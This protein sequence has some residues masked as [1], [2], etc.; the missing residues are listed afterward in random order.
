MNL[1]NDYSP[2]NPN[3]ERAVLG[4]C[5]LSQEALSSAV[6]VLKPD[7]FYVTDNRIA[8]EILVEMYLADKPVD[9]VTFSEELKGRGVYDRLGGQPFLAEL[10]GEITTT[11]NVDY[12]AE[13]VREYAIRRR[14]IYAG[15]KII[16]LSH[17]QDLTTKE[18]VEEI[19]KLILEASEN[20]NSS[21]FRHVREIIGPVFVDVEERY[22]NTGE[23]FSGFSSGFA[24]LDNL[25]GGFQPG[26]LNII[27]ARPS[28]GKTAFAVT[29]KICRY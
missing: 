24:D 17:R 7:D 9:L 4:A 8:Y 13:I 19:E 23:E 2:N 18:I 12:H 25:T 1:D 21:E 6:E 11:A 5:V 27:A 29:D 26:T 3:A 10:I 15:N 16:A 28:M 20:R 22:K 14:L